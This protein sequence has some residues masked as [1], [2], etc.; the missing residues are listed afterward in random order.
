MVDSRGPG[1]ELDAGIGGSGRAMRPAEITVANN[2][3]A[4]PP[5][6]TLFKGTEGEYWR[7]LGNF[8][9]GAAV[10]RAGVKVADL[11]LARAAAGLLRPA[12]DSPVRGAA[13]GNFTTIKSDIDGQPRAGK[14]DAGCDQ[15]YDARAANRPLAAADVGP[16]WLKR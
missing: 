4:V 11:K 8:A 14:L 13:E 15:L 2:L 10:E 12:V 1:I 6:G 16:A 3:F 7:W 9:S 5:G